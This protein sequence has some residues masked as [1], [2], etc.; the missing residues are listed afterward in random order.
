[1]ERITL[2]SSLRFRQAEL[3]AQ[4]Y[5]S[6]LQKIFKFSA[7]S[8]GVVLSLGIIAFN[9]QSPTFFKTRS[10]IPIVAAASSEST[11]TPLML[12]INIANNGSVLLRGARVTDVFGRTI[13]TNLSWASADFTWTVE[14]PNN[15]KFFDHKGQ[16]QTISDIKVGDIV[17]VT[18]K[19]VSKN[20]KMVISAEFVRE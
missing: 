7:V 14:A 2:G 11:T 12:G 20:N 1:M 17:T 13:Q 19:L 5:K 18:G 15:A 9:I 8:A 3:G 16:K 4:I 6:G 10:T